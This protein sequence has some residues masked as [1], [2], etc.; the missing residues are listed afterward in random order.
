V[1]ETNYLSTTDGQS[2]TTQAMPTLL[3]GEAVVGAGYDKVNGLFYCVVSTTTASRIFVSTTGTSGWT[4]VVGAALLPHQAQ[5]FASNGGE[6]ATMMNV[7]GVWRMMLSIDGAVTW[8]FAR[9]NALP[10]IAGATV[11]AHGNGFVYQNGTSYA[12][13]HQAG[14]PEP[15]I[16]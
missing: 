1:A 16:Y 10:A 14:T 12:L 15:L 7:N 9:M 11:E 8:G 3:T 6:L 2:W 13:T 4:V 5:G